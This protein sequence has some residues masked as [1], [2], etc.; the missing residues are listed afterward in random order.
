MDSAMGQAPGTYAEIED[1][2]V[3]PSPEYLLRLAR[4]L[5]LSEADYEAVHSQLYECAAAQSLAEDVPL[6]P[7]PAWQEVI[8]NQSGMAYLSDRRWDVRMC[9]PAFAGMFPG[10]RP[11]KNAMEW[12]ILDE[13]VRDTVLIDWETAWAPFA[14]TQFRAVR[15]AFPDDA[16]LQ[17]MH[18]RILGDERARRIYEDPSAVQVHR[19]GE[20]IRPMRHAMH[21]V[22][23][24]RLFMA[25]PDNAP[26]A[27][28]VTLRFQKSDGAWT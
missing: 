9:S 19:A 27:R 17:R 1:G 5:R 25:Q 21:G 3:T 22:G 13:S 23:H 16:E 20:D 28:F 15:L 10:G 8:E 14:L 26:G 2:T 24:V 6:L 18:E 12:M 11:P 7:D 4:V